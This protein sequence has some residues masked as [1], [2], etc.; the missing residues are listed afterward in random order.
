MLGERLKELR[1]SRNL[2]QAEVGVQLGL[3]AG[4]ISSYERGERMPDPNTLKR[5][6]DFYGVSAD[7]LLNRT[8]V[9]KVFRTDSEAE[10]DA[11]EQAEICNFWFRLK[12]DKKLRQ[13]I[14]CV[15]QLEDSQI[16]AMIS[17]AQV[18]NQAGR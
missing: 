15:Q 10:A 3:S 17:V 6:A 14:R 11:R 7:Y 16:D 8:D 18:L 13:L 12:E 9:P 2:T 4:A 5:L 1:L